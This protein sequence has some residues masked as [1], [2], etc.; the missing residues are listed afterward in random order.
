MKTGPARNLL[1]TLASSFLRTNVP[2]LASSFLRTNG[3]S[4]PPLAAEGG[5]ELVA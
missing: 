4:L 2:T 1:L 5:E 3:H